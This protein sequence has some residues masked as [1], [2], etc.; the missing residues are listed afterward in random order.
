[1]NLKVLE[2]ESRVIPEFPFINFTKSG[3]VIFNAAAT[4]QLSF[5]QAGSKVAF[6]Q[7]QDAP[8]DF[9]LTNTVANSYTL[10]QYKQSAG[11]PMICFQSKAFV[12]RIRKA[13]KAPD[14]KPFKMRIATVGTEFNGNMYHALI[15]IK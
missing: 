7:D 11:R 14:D 2:P 5:L 9:Y 4:D 8:F 12:Q 13:Y 10:R 15:L 6:Y 3:N 1:M